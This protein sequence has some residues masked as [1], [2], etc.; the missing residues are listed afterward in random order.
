MSKRSLGIHDGTFHG[1]E[2]SAAALLILYDL[3]DRDKITRTRDLN[4][5]KTCDYVCD[6]GGVFDPASKRFDHHQSDYSGTLSSAGMVLNYLLD[7]KII[8][9]DWHRFLDKQLIAGVDAIDNGLYTPPYGLCTFSG[10][11]SEFVPVDHDSPPESYTN[12]FL[13]ALDFCLNHIKRLRARFDYI[14]AAKVVIEAEMK[15]QQEVL[16]FDRSL[17]WVES[18]FALGG[19]DHPAKFLIMPAGEHWKLRGIPPTYDRRM[20]VRV[21]LPESWAG[22]LESDLKKVTGIDGAIFCHKGR[23]ISI[24]ETKADAEKALK[25]VLNG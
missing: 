17:P 23:F 20:E 1:D 15:K 25:E 4:I 3:I 10:L 21:P 14:Q 12:A 9:K 8:D 6:V 7:Q 22:L 18:F 16:Y 19:E 5:L 13:E 2:V 24:W 11:I